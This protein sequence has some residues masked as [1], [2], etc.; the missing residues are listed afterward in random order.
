MRQ[1]SKTIV[2]QRSELETFFNEALEYV[3]N[4]VVKERQIALREKLM[5]ASNPTMRTNNGGRPP[6]PPSS[7]GTQGPP[8][9]LPPPRSTSGPAST[10]EAE[11]GSSALIHNTHP[12]F[13]RAEEG[14]GQFD[15]IY[16]G[17]PDDPPSTAS[18]S[19]RALVP[20]S[21]S[22]GLPP[23]K[24]SSE[25]AGYP[26]GYSTVGGKRGQAGKG[27][28]QQGGSRTDVPESD[29]DFSNL[30]WLDKERVLRILLAKINNAS[31]YERAKLEPPESST[32][33]RV[34]VPVGV[35]AMP[36]RSEMHQGGASTFVTQNY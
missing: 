7:S 35:Q 5:I 17:A 2:R 9:P 32:G 23:I 29:A 6:W 30:S 15:S 36:A 18:S 3:R 21:P 16:Q 10:V 31:R 24:P 8:L 28:Q 20:S 26:G 33:M 25:P 1:L 19:V 12:F 34:V 4:E 13:H 11:R 27:P 22:G 14:G